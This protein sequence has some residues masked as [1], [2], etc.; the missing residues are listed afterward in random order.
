M[1]TPKIRSRMTVVAAAQDLISQGTSPV[2]DDLARALSL[3]GSGFGEQGAFELIAK[4]SPEP[5]ATR[6]Y[7]VLATASTGGIDLAPALLETARELRTQRR[8]EVKRTATK[9]Q[10]AMIIPDLAF[11][12]PVLLVF[13]V[14]PVKLL[15][16]GAH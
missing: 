3:I 15:L 10:M 13:L 6:F 2:I 1:L 14:A 16:F 4:E 5:A 11:M 8:E 9:K 12:A 7:N